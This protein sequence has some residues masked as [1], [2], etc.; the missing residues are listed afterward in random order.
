METT[1]DEKEKWLLLF[2]MNAAKTEIIVTVPPR[3]DFSFDFGQ[4]IFADS[5]FNSSLALIE[6]EQ[7]QIRNSECCG[8]QRLIPL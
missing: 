1:K 2:G 7:D 8:N 6:I 5:I 3:L 4:M